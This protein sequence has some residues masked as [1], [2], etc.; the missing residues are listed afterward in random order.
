MCVRFHWVDNYS[1]SNVVL[2]ISFIETRVL[3]SLLRSSLS[4]TSDENLIERFESFSRARN[5]RWTA[6][7]EDG[8]FASL[9]HLPIKELSAFN[10]V[11]LRGGKSNS[12]RFLTSSE[13]CPSDVREFHHFPRDSRLRARRCE[14]YSLKSDS[15]V[16]EGCGTWKVHSRNK[17]GKERSLVCLICLPF[18]FE[19]DFKSMRRQPSP[20]CL[21]ISDERKKIKSADRKEKK[22]ETSRKNL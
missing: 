22:V 4:S 19:G 9:N 17:Q 1:S 10:F 15:R 11:A 20:S 8:E 5:L 7:D 16:V 12:N 14:I 2:A 6:S 18:I 21:Q 13:V 3:D